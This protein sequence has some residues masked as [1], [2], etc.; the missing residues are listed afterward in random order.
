MEKE[1]LNYIRKHQL[2]SC[3]N[4]TK[5]KRLINAITSKKEYAPNVKIKLIFDKSEEDEKIEFCP[6]W[7][8]NIEQ[9]GFEV[10]EWLKINSIEKEYLGRL[11]EPKFTD[12]YEF[13]KKSIKKSNV[14]YE[15]ENSIFTIYGYKR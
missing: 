15:Y 8:K 9:D 5:W 7:W 2:S 13:I 6:V 11:V 10:I 12:H 14:N 4:N 1:I 3:M